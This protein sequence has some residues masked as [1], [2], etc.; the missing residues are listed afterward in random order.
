MVM[1]EDTVNAE[2]RAH[3]MVPTP[4]GKIGKT[5]SSQGKV[6]EFYRKYRK[7]KA[8]F[9]SDLNFRQFLFLPVKMQR[10]GPKANLASF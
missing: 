9:F 3:A 8:I 1:L 5:F 7:I 2:N 10:N 4:T 6:Q